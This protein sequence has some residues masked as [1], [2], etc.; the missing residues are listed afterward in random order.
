MGFPHFSRWAL[1]V[2]AAAAMLAGCGGSQPPTGAPGAMPQSGGLAASVKRDQSWV[3]GLRP[4]S[5]EEAV[6]AYSLIYNFQANPDGQNPDARLIPFD[7]ALYGT[8]AVGGGTRCGGKGCGTIFKV[9]TTGTETVL[10][11]FK[12]QGDGAKPLAEL[13]AVKSVLYGTTS[14]GGVSCKLAKVGGCGTVFSIDTSGAEHALYAFAGIPDGANPQGPLTFVSGKLYGTTANGGTKAMQFPKGCG[15]VYSI[16]T[17]GKEKVLYRFQG[18]P[19]DGCGPT[20]NL[21][22]LNGTLYGTTMYGGVPFEVGTVFAISLSGKERVLYAPSAGYTFAYPSGLVAMGG[23]LYGSSVEG[24]THAGGTV[25][26][27]TT[28][29]DEHIVHSFSQDRMRDGNRPSGRLIGVNGLLYGTTWAGGQ[30]RGGYG[31]VYSLSP[32]GVLRVLYRFKGPP[33]GDTP[34]VGVSDAKGTLYGTTY[35]GGT[36]CYHYGCQ[37]GYGT[38]FRLSR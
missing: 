19:Y 8:T 12:N 24:G 25:Y 26:A 37:G 34:Y 11:R 1:S 2:C 21:V 18:R 4:S 7:G 17:S 15:V 35:Y 14:N 9:T 20:G 5:L 30:E 32:S 27:V 23:V 36:G 28:S 3:R 6:S 16:D 33:D 10:H 22:Y 29:G 31:L 38:V 13:V